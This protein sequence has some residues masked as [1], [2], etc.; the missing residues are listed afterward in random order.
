MQLNYK[1]K[2]QVDQTVIVKTGRF[3]C[4][5]NADPK[6]LREHKRVLTRKRTVNGEVT[7]NL[8]LAKHRGLCVHTSANFEWDPRGS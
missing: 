7:P 6:P 8:E 3:I 5:E 4:M 1:C 2:L